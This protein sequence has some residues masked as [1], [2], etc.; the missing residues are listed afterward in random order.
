M[1]IEKIQ[2]EKERREREK[3]EAVP[4]WKRPVMKAI[5]LRKVEEQVGVFGRLSSLHV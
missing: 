4:E 3:I 5:E 2:R 1:E